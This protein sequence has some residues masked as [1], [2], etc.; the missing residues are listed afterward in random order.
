MKSGLNVHLLG[1]ILCLASPSLSLAWCSNTINLHECAKYDPITGNCIGAT[2]NLSKLEIPFF[3]A[4]N[5][6]DIL[7]YFPKDFFTCFEYSEQAIACNY[8]N[9]YEPAVLIFKRNY[10]LKS[11][12]IAVVEELSSVKQDYSK[13]VGWTVILITVGGMVIA[14]AIALVIWKL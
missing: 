11:T 2:C 3:N 1:L 10:E 7:K 8:K 12:S 6:Q 14:M 4:Q 5:E 13:K 9:P